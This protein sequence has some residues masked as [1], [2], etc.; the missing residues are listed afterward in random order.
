M[1][2]VHERCNLRLLGFAG[3]RCARIVFELL[4]LRVNGERSVVI[5]IGYRNRN[6][7]QRIR[8]ANTGQD[9]AILR[10]L[11]NLIDIGAWFG[12]GDVAEMEM[13]RLTSRSALRLGHLHI[14]HAVAGAFRH[15]SGT[16]DRL[17]EENEFILAEPS[18]TGQ[19][20]LALK[21][22]IAL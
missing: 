18:T 16:I 4:H 11:M 3:N 2:L 8:G 5:V 15:G 7:V 21:V 19:S 6:L 9:V 10:A 22:S 12:V 17:Q 14:D 13:H 1:V 20:L